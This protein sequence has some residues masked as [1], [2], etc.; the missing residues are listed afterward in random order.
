MNAVG[1]RLETAQKAK[2]R[3]TQFRLNLMSC[4]RAGTRSRKGK[5]AARKGAFEFPRSKPL[6]PPLPLHSRRCLC[7]RTA[8][9]SGQ[10]RVSAEPTWEA[11]S[12]PGSEEPER[13]GASRSS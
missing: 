10:A 5:T 4:G 13:S 1:K 2:L 11:N 7:A 6:T 12:S 3:C 9:A 8:R